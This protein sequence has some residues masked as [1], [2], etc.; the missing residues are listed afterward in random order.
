VK[1]TLGN[2]VILFTA[3]NRPELE[4]V[5]NSPPKIH[6]RLKI[7]P[8]L[9]DD[10]PT[11]EFYGLPLPVKYILVECANLRDIRAKYFRVSSV[12]ELFESVD[13]RS[14]IDFIKETHF[15]HKL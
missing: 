12:G 4:T 15:Y 5:N 11:S 6:G 3:K 8:T 13:N 7:S 14:V 2:P 9:S 10:P 1:T